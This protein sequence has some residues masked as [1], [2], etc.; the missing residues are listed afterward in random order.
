MACALTDLTYLG[1]RLVAE[2]C[3][4]ICSP[5]DEGFP[6]S[7]PAS[8]DLALALAQPRASTIDHNGNKK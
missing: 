3:R 5:Q 7:G 4:Y 6:F 1:Y 8:T 2:I